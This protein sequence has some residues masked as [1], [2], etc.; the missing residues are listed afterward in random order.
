MSGRY[1]QQPPRTEP[2]EDFSS[3]VP[4]EDD[5]VPC[6]RIDAP[7]ISDEELRAET[8]ELGA[9]LQAAGVLLTKDGGV[10]TFKSVPGPTKSRLL[11]RLKRRRMSRNKFD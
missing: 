11:A 2:R 7:A 4:T 6:I 8:A 10:A 9:R 1:R 3:L 5:M